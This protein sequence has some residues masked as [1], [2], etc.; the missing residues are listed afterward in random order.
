M[1]RKGEQPVVKR[2]DHW[3]PTHP[4]GHMIRT[5]SRWFSAWRVY[6]GYPIERLA[7]ASGIAVGRIWAVEMG[8]ALA[9]DEL[10]AL[11]DVW[12]ISADDLIASMPSPDMLVD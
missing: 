3:T 7:R 4:V 5:G 2:E 9:R 6:K 8:G 1:R 10:D 11:A 12:L